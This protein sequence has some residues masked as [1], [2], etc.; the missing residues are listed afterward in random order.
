MSGKTFGLQ[1]SEVTNFYQFK[2]I[3]RPPPQ[4]RS[5]D[6]KWLSVRLL[7]IRQLFFALKDAFF[8]TT[9]SNLPHKVILYDIFNSF[10]ST[11]GMDLNIF[12]PGANWAP[13][14]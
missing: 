2:Q 8:N 1:F 10:P 13:N 4:I 6:W 11:S 7:E 3:A 5:R 9:N 12:R 14:F